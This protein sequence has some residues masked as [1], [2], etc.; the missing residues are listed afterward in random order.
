MF[1]FGV[2]GTWYVQVFI[3]V[4]QCKVTHNF[5]KTNIFS[6]N[7]CTLLCFLGNLGDQNGQKQRYILLLGLQGLPLWL[8]LWGGG[9]VHW[10]QV[11]RVQAFEVVLCFRGVFPAF[12][13]LSR[14]ALGALFLK[15]AF[16]RVLRAF[17]AWFV[18]VVWVCLVLALC[19]ACGAFVCVSG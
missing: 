16:I 11:V 8:S 15:Y 4:S 5:D 19:V 18:V 1:Y 17:L 7:I 6:K 14:F 3:P 12:C 13:P 2:P 9:G 10:W